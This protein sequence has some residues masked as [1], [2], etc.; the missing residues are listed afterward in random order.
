MVRFNVVHAA[1]HLFLVMVVYAETYMAMLHVSSHRVLY[2]GTGARVW[3]L[4]AIIP[5]VLSLGFGQTWETYFFHHIKH[6]HIEDNGPS[7]LSSTAP[8]QRDSFSHFMMYFARFLLGIQVEL[9]LYFWRKGQRSFAAQVIFGENVSLLFFAC[10]TFYS[11]PGGLTVFVIP[12][13]LMRF[14]MMASNWGQHA[15][16]GDN[17]DAHSL[18]ILNS[19]Y[20]ALAFNDGFHLSH[21]QNSMRHWSEHPAAAVSCQ[22]ASFSNITFTGDMNFSDIWLMLMM[23]NYRELERRFVFSDSVNRPAPAVII[24]ELKRQLAPCCSVKK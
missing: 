1:L 13:L 21:H 4:N 3:C 20:N 10:A 14:F 15:F 9:G 8:Y 2:R 19:S 5:Y 17:K 11:V 12:W 7:D 16:I 6:H 24:S 23:K 22:P 18:T